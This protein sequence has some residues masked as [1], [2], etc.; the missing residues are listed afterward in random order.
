MDS[1]NNST[2]AGLPPSAF[3]CIHYLRVPT[4]GLHT[5]T[6]RLHAGL[7][8]GTTTSTYD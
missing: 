8:D 1:N 5:D 4:Q 6:P 2:A 7:A 3:V